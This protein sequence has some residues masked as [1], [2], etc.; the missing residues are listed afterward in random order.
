MNELARFWEALLQVVREP[1][2]NLTATA[3]VAAM[4]TVVL[5]M[6]ILVL[7]ILLTRT[8]GDEHGADA[9]IKAA[10]PD[11]KQTK[12]HTAVRPQPLAWIV[13]F[14]LVASALAGAWFMS[15]TQTYCAEQ[16]HSSDPAVTAILSDGAPHADVACIDCHE[17]PGLAG[18]PAAAA[19]RTGYLLSQYVGTDDQARALVPAERC[20]GCH[21]SALDK[22][23]TNDDTATRMSHKE[24]LASGMVCADCHI[25]VAHVGVTENA[26][27][28]PCLDCHNGEDASAACITCHI[29]D[30]SLAATEGRIYGT[31]ELGPIVDCGGCHDQASC[32]ACHGLRMPHSSEFLAYRHARDAAFGRKALCF[33]QCHVAEECQACH[34]GRFDAGR[35][36]GHNENWRYEHSLIDSSSGA[37]EGY[38]S[39]HQ[40]KMPPQLQDQRFCLVC[41]DS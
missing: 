34:M 27:M 30:P 32:D 33:E 31:V 5:V 9:R 28:T 20:A 15:G 10:P 36:T 14:A 37:G 35:V 16:C 41:H 18:V 19:A 29:G 38:C 4:V 21:R 1:T 25:S 39:C 6:I 22:V 13:A 24:P 2:S 7:L 17:D 40:Q 8:T 23:I 3:L 11:R 12:D 26:G